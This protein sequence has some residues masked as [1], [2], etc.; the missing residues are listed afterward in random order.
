MKGPALGETDTEDSFQRRAV[1]NNE[2]SIEFLRNEDSSKAQISQ[3]RLRYGT[4]SRTFKKGESNDADPKQ[5]GPQTQAPVKKKR[6]PKKQMISEAGLSSK[7]EEAFCRSPNAPQVSALPEEGYHFPSLKPSKN[8]RPI[9][10]YRLSCDKA[11]DAVAAAYPVVS[12]RHKFLNAVDVLAQVC[13]EFT[14]KSKESLDDVTQSRPKTTFKAEMH[15]DFEIIE[16]F[17]ENF[18]RRLVELVCQS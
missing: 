9:S 11:D 16:D 15:R 18:D 1:L 12:F 4:Q 17:G 6:K 3:K 13:S 7:M 8:P 14:L 5:N 2:S 10:V